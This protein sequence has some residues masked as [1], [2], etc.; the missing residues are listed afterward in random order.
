M[1]KWLVTLNINGMFCNTYVDIDGE[2]PTKERLEKI[3]TDN[4]YSC[5]WIGERV[6]RRV[7]ITFMQKLEEGK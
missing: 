4:E 7:A 2:L 6:R 5:N 3:I 1:S